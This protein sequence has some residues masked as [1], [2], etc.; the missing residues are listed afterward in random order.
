MSKK[1]SRV[2]WHD[3]GP[4]VNPHSRVES[5]APSDGLL[6]CSRFCI[7][8]NMSCQVK[9]CR[10]W[11]DYKKEHNCSLISIYEN[12]RMTLREVA[13]RLGISFARVKQIET[14]ALKKLKKRCLQNGLNF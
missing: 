2:R 7:S 12:G 6:K 1:K 3:Y 9:E 10:L 4:T 14:A 11:I 8:H 13:D 5:V